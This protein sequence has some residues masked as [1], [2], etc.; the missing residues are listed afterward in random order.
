ME[1]IGI[2]CEYNPLHNGHLY[3]LQKIKEKYPDSLVI[4][5]LNGY[6]LERGEISLISKYDKTRLALMY[7]VDIVVELPFLFGSQA[8]DIFAYKAIQLLNYLKVERIIFGSESND[9]ELL[10]KLADS[11]LDRNYQEKVKDLLQMGKNYP[12]A[13]SKA[14]DKDIKSPND[15]LGISYWKAI[16]LINP[17]I[18]AETIQRTNDYHDILEDKQ[19]VSAANIRER[20]KNREDIQKYV[21]REVVNYLRNVQEDLLFNL[22]KYKIMTDENLETYLDVDEGIEYRIRKYVEKSCNYQE[23]I[24]NIKTKRYTYN[25]IR[26][27]LIHI[28][29]GIKKS[30]AKEPIS[31]LRILGFRKTGQEYLKKMRKE[32]EGIRKI[33]YES[34]TW[35]YELRAARIY[36]MLTGSHCYEEDLK[37]QPIK[38]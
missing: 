5:V 2:I 25:K 11:Q 38:I 10:K 6:F 32:L 23:L 12:T 28:L 18:I 3:H 1:V 7:G 31:Y 36:D 26:R 17:S 30:D 8:A 21:P 14:L 20:L 9:S 22:L 29:L 19:I 27:M 15:L 33:N 34:R 13:L 16:R 37:N 24:C 35:E 4:L